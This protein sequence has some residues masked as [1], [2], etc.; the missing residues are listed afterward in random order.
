M[1]AWKVGN[2]LTSCCCCPVSLSPCWI[3]TKVSTH[4]SLV[5]AGFAARAGRA[6]TSIIAAMTKA[7]V[8]IEKMRFISMLHLLPQGGRGCSRPR[9]KA[10]LSP[11][12]CQYCADVYDPAVACGPGEREG[13]AIGV[14]GDK[15]ETS[16]RQ[17][18]ANLWP[19][20]DVA[21]PRHHEQVA[22]GALGLKEGT[23][24]DVA[25]LVGRLLDVR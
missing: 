24:D 8:T 5:G 18:H 7:T 3:A 10:V 11:L 1:H 16:S 13:G 14:E 17:K 25:H 12:S 2:S 19:E 9:P 4:S 15:G 21:A 6:M 20:D 23:S 22:V